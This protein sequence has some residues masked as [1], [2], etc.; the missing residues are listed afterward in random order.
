MKQLTEK[1][2][3]ELIK[4][5]PL[6]ERERL[7]RRDITPTWLEEEIE[8]ARAEMRNDLILGIPWA[9]IYCFSLWQFGFSYGTAII[10]C[11]GAVYFLFVTIK[12]GNYGLL[13]KKVKVFEQML[14]EMRSTGG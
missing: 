1:R 10:F 4:P 3:K 11:L 14:A 13:K 5:L 12:R 9:L 6:R 7:R 2:F 8:T